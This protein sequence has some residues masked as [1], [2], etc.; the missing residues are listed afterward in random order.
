MKPDIEE[1]REAALVILTKAAVFQKN[2]GVF[3]HNNN[4]VWICSHALEEF[5]I[6][7]PNMNLTDFFI[8][9][10]LYDQKYHPDEEYY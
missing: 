2:L 6:F 1:L 5:K 9:T 3:M 8:Q 10:K 7:F 4:P